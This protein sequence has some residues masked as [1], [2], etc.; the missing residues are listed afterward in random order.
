MD[1]LDPDRH[2]PGYWSRFHRRVLEAAAGELALRRVRGASTVS[3][4]VFSWG[5]TVVP[6]ALAAALLA[7][8][9]L[10]SEPSGAPSRADITDV[11]EL[12]AGDLEDDPIPVVLASESYASAGDLEEF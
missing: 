11:E 8:I 2:D 1:S 7:G 10:F 4:T 3:E 9:L 5:R 12:L 6:A